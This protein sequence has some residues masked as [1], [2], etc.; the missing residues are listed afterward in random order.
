M[1]RKVP[2]GSSQIRLADSYLLLVRR[3][4]P[5]DVLISARLRIRLRVLDHVIEH[6]VSVMN[7]QLCIRVALLEC[8]GQGSQAVIPIQNHL[9]L[10]LNT[11]TAIVLTQRKRRQVN[12]RHRQEKE[13]ARPS[14]VHLI[15]QPGVS[16]ED[17]VVQGRVI[18]PPAISHVVNPNEERKQAIL[19]SPRCVGGMRAIPRQKLALDLVD[20]RE[21][22]GRVGRHEFGIHGRTAVGEIV[23]FDERGVV[24]C[25]EEVDPVWAVGGCVAWEG[26]VAEGVGGVGLGAVD[27]KAG[28]RVA[29]TAEKC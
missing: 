4:I 2:K 5:R 26:R 28:L 6:L 16:R 14:L 19:P 27:I 13:V 11:I 8:L 24:G 7:E 29:V 12:R 23:C 9:A 18:E 22:G 17:G 25:G 15:Q 3:T 1:P 20:K 10:S 21:H